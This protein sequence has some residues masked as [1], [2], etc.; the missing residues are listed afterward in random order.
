[1]IQLSRLEKSVASRA[2]E[3]FI[4]RRIALT[5]AEGEFVTIMGP[6]GAGKSTLLSILGMLDQTTRA[7]R[8]CR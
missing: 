2:G 3:T 5:I 6:S 8:S 7:P 1:M 4:L